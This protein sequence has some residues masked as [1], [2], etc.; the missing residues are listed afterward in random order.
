MYLTFFQRKR[1]VMGE[2]NVFDKIIV[3]DDVYK[4]DDFANFLTVSRKSSFTCVYVFHS[5]CPTRFSWQMILWQAKIFNI[6]PG[7]FTYEY[8]PHRDLWLNR[9]YF[10]ISNSSDKSA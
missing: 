1:H 5:I 4:S 6:F 3:R 9:L 8:I 7:S 10:E 2:N